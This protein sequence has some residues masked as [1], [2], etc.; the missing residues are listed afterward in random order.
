MGLI[1]THCHLD[2][3][4]GTPDEAVAE[5]RAAGVEAVVAVGIDLRSSRS[6]AALAAR[7]DG[8]YAAVGVHP[9]DAVGFDGVVRTGLERLLGP[10]AAWWPSASAAST[11]TATSRRATSSARCSS[12]SSIWRARP[13]SRSACT[14]ARPGGE[15]FALLTEHAG[16]LRVILHCFSTPE[17]VELCN[18]RGYYVSFAGNLTYKNSD[19]LRK[20]AAGGARRPAAGRDR[21]A[22]PGA[23][24][25]PRAR[26]PARLRGHTAQ[27]LARLRG[28][29]DDAGR[30]RHERQRPPRLRPRAGRPPSRAAS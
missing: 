28:W 22:V 13:A 4:K 10:A 25:A 19:E 26:Q 27:F 29:S 8:V 2:M 17:Y 6:A 21:R 7:V 12:S 30:R 23:H 5:A 20:A 15:T 3:L 14:A 11:S 1:D 18:E 24:A 16:G 9:H